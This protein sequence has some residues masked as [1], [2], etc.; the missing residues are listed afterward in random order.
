MF[1]HHIT[2]SD[3]FHAVENKCPLCALIWEEL[4]LVNTDWALLHDDLTVEQ[5]TLLQKLDAADRDRVAGLD[6]RFPAEPA[7]QWAWGYSQDDTLLFLYFELAT[8]NLFVDFELTPSSEEGLNVPL[9]PLAEERDDTWQL[10]LAKAWLDRCIATHSECQSEKS[11]W[12]PTRLLELGSSNDKFLRLIDTREKVVNKPYVTLSHCWG[13]FDFFKLTNENISLMLTGIDTDILAS[14]FKDAIRTARFLGV[15]YLWIDALCILQDSKEDWELESALMGK[16]Y[17]NG[18]CNLSA[19]GSKN[20]EE[21]LFT[22]H[23]KRYPPMTY[24]FSVTSSWDNENNGFWDVRLTYLRKGHLLN[25][26]LLDRGWLFRKEL[27]RD[28]ISISDPSSFTGSVINMMHVKVTPM[29]SPLRNELLNFKHQFEPIDA[30]KDVSLQYASKMLKLW[31]QTVSNFSR[32]QLTREKDK[33]PALSGIAKAIQPFLTNRKYLAGLWRDEFSPNFLWFVVN[34]KM[35]SGQPSRRPQN[36][37]APSWSWASID[38]GEVVMR[39]QSDEC[40]RHDGNSDPQVQIIDVRIDLLTSDPTGQVKDGSLQL[41]GPLMTVSRAKS[42][43]NEMGD[44]KLK[45]NNVWFPWVVPR[46]DVGESNR[47]VENLHIIPIQEYWNVKNSFN[48]LLLEPTGLKMG[49]FKRYGWMY[50]QCS[51]Y[52]IYDWESVKNEEWLEFEENDG[53]GRS[54][55]TII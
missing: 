26:P 32:C 1:P 10:S 42:R 34:S 49:Q 28:E 13:L 41:F 29:F 54:K 2:I 20:G 55:F 45:I 40:Y 24:P 50:L 3:L 15:Q 8:S 12:V 31:A 36:Y 22:N 9:I 7:V 48:C 47:P 44:I 46:P 38:G 25:G 23:C 4:I 43:I 27:W 53:H 18:L 17:R 16:V 52:N 37:R 21:G 33:L 14:T 19:T 5:N 39:S 11:T 30:R 51:H 6:S 35:G